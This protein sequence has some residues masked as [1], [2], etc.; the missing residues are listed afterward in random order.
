MKLD[1]DFVVSGP[2]GGAGSSDSSGG[3]VTY[4][5]GAQYDW[6]RVAL[7]LGYEKYDFSGGI[8]VKET[9]LTFFYKL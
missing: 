6:D 2:G 1:E 7:R 5:A 3:E 9:S 4:F 8:D